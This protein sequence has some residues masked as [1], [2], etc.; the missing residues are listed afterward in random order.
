MGLQQYDVEPIESIWSGSTHS[1]EVQLECIGK[2]KYKHFVLEYDHSVC[3]YSNY[4]EVQYP[5]SS[6]HLVNLNPSCMSE[7]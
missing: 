2:E 5:C 7:R 6:T 3:A 1:E 4:C